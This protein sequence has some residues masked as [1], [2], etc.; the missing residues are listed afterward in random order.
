[1][2]KEK[3]REGE[4]FFVFLHRMRTEK[5]LLGEHYGYQVKVDRSFGSGFRVRDFG[6][7]FRS[8]IGIDR[9]GSRCD[10]NLR[11]SIFK[12]LR[13][14]GGHNEDRCIQI[15]SYPQRPFADAVRSEVKK[16]Q[17]LSIITI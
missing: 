4:T 8:G 15:S 16:A 2:K 17:R 7:V 10:C 14:G 11:D 12:V 13:K 6:G 3:E 1:M 5:Q 9:T